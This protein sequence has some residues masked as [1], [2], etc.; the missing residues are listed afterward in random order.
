MSDAVDSDRRHL[1]VALSCSLVLMATEVAVS[2]VSG[3]LAL[4]A[5][6]GHLLTDVGAIGGSIW[7]MSLARRP[8]SP[9]W[10]FGLKR[11]EILAAAVNG[12]TLFGIGALVVLEAIRRLIHPPSVDGAPMVAVAIFGIT[13]TLLSTIALSRANRAS[14]N[15]EGVFQHVLTDMF[16]FLGTAV[17]GVVIMTTSWLRADGV[18]SLLVAGLV[19][20][21]AWRLL[22]AS[23]RVLLEGTPETV[24]LDE[25]RRHLTELPEVIGVHDLHAWTLT[26]DLPALSAHVVVTEECLQDGT[27]AGLLDRLQGCLAQ[28][29]DVEHSTFQLE[30]ATHPAHEP[31]THD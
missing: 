5:D 23:G 28:H 19:L 17:A 22:S 31:G 18:A 12:L 11:A 9:V 7:V 16:G 13:L 15:I 14:L 4:L 26:S 24:D 6:A 3:S 10:S 21:A 30:P 29:F 20:K 1:L 8:A 27:A 2:I 25:V